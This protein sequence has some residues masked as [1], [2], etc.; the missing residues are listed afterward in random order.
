MIDAGSSGELHVSRRCILPALRNQNIRR[1]E[2]VVC[3]HAD[4]DHIAGVVPILRA[5][6]VGI[7]RIPP[8]MLQ[9]VSPLETEAEAAILQAVETRERLIEK[10]ASATVLFPNLT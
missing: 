10:K 2:G 5:I 1:L 6:P 8:L 9:E 4:L 3:T 7:L